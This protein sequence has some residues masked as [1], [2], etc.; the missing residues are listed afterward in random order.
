[1][2]QLILTIFCTA[3][4]F[5]TALA[6]SIETELS[7]S[8]SSASMSLNYTKDL[9]KKEDPEQWAFNAT[10]GASRST[11]T[12]STGQQIADRTTDLSGGASW[13]KNKR[14]NVSGDFTYSKT[15]EE[16]M[17]NWGPSFTGAYTFLFGSDEDDSFQ[18][19]LKLSLGVSNQNY[20]QTFVVT[21]APR[22]PRQKPP[23]GA[24]TIVQTGVTFG[25]KWNV[26]EWLSIKAS[27]TTYRYD[28]DV[29]TFIATLDRAP[30]MTSG[31]TNA[32]S[33]FSSSYTKLAV[34][35]YFL[36]RWELMAQMSQSIS[37]SD[38][39]VTKASRGMLYCDINSNWRVGAG[40]EQ[41]VGTSVSDT[42]LASAEY[43]Y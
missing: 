42:V 30:Q 43:N 41:S 35:Y 38:D 14:I 29:K 12:D 20:R 32:A 19:S 25:A 34:S 16:N 37:A 10:L 5:Q 8:T 6:D 39:S 40:G 23:T 28:K 1:M 26:L 27:H 13:T 15:P 21:Q 11:T 24:I 33:S 3:V 4:Y 36:E 2:K 17:D 9:S 31:M 7:N 22:G 18:Q